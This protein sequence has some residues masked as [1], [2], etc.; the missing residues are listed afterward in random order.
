MTIELLLIIENIKIHVYNNA[1]RNFR[2]QNIINSEY[3]KFVEQ[4]KIQVSESR[5]QAARSVNSE[6]IKLYHHI[7][8]EILKR[9]NKY[10]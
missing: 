2:D 4:L 3:L 8:N 1:N 9:Q 5:Y 6:L 10:G 7:G